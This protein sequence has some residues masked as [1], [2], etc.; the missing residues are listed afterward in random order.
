[1]IPYRPL[2]RLGL[3]PARYT[4]S[5][6]HLDRYADEGVDG[7][8]RR[9]RAAGV[10]RVVTVGSGIEPSRRAVAIARRHPGW[11]IAAAGIH[12]RNAGGLDIDAVERLIDDNRDVVWA[13]GEIGLDQ[14]GQIGTSL[15]VQ[16]VAFTLQLRVAV[17]RGLPVIV[18]AA[19]ANRLVAP[20]L[21]EHRQHLPA[22]I[23]HYF[24]GT[25]D[26]LRSYLELDCYI[27]F[28]RLLLKPEHSDLRRLVP[29]VPAGRLLAETDSYPLPGRT[30]EPRDLVP[31]VRRLARLRGVSTRAMAR[32]STANLERALR[33]EPLPVDWAPVRA[34]LAGIVAH[35]TS[36]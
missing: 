17:K 36:Q 24:A 13:V 9:A 28:G 19:G 29:F 32:Q 22:I 27:S 7:M 30:T 33:L 26:S 21:R 11:V 5:H 4:D 18:H 34:R 31:L 15:K 35:R 20:I 23:I 6:V 8:V 25:E 3:L 2:D 12:P 16:T 10:A 1:M 14:G